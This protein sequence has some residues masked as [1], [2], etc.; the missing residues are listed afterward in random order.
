MTC[1]ILGLGTAVPETVN[2]QS[3]IM[4]M[5]ARLV[6]ENERQQRLSRMLYRQSG[7]EKRHCVVSVDR[8]D[9]WKSR[10]DPIAPGM[11]PR[12]SER[13]QI[14][15]EHALPLALRACRRA[16][17]DAGV[18]PEEVTHIVT[19]SCTGFAAPGVDVG[20]IKSLQL[21]PTTQRIHVGFMGCH[22][23]INGMRA[24][25]GL[26]AADP[27]A[28]VLMCCVELCCLHFRMAWDDNS[29]IG[30][31]LFA[32]GSAA[33]V[34]AGDNIQRKPIWNLE[35]TGSCLIQDSEDQM[36]WHVGDHGFDMKLTPQVA[37]SIEKALLPWMSTWL[38]QMGTSVEQIDAWA[39]HPGGPKI[40]DAVES[41]LN[42]PPADIRFSREILR[43]YGNMSSPTVLFVLDRM[44]SESVSGAIVMLGFGP[45]LM[46]ESALLS[47]ID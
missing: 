32:D 35:A 31:A 20:L 19:V 6:C 16:L 22:G 2:L 44:R 28:V 30:N 45:G 3:D 47:S 38:K 34:A 8:G 17:D 7:V 9:D 24:V 40:I 27:N 11:G 42:L 23:A 26:T 33:I 36:A 39:L 13:M 18:S 29:I 4:E 5:S 1:A 46:A 43:T 10:N 25:H 12:T 15:Q 21:R 37:D 14:Y 41:V